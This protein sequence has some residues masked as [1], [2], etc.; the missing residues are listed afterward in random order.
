VKIASKEYLSVTFHFMVPD[1]GSIAPDAMYELLSNLYLRSNVLTTE[2]LVR[3]SN[4]LYQTVLFREGQVRNW[5]QHLQA[6]VVRDLSVY[7][8][9]IID[10]ATEEF[11]SHSLSWSFAPTHTHTHI[12]LHRILSSPLE[13][14]TL[15]ITRTCTSALTAQSTV[16]LGSQCFIDPLTVVPLPRPSSRAL[17][18]FLHTS[19]LPSQSALVAFVCVAIAP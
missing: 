12:R 4:Q 2:Q 9:I 5:T 6:E 1:H 15:S 11:V 8:K 10:D 16:L 13:T 17:T 14:D 18:Y 3:L 7:A 19:S